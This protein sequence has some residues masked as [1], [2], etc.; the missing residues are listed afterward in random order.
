MAKNMEV[1]SN[2]IN[3]IGSG[4]TIEG[5]IT[6]TGDIRVDGILK[7]NLNTKGKV[8]IGES[9]KV[10]GEIYCKILEVEG[11]IE[12]KVFTS[13]LLSFRASSR[14]VGDITT[15][16]LAIEPGAVFS[17]KCDMTGTNNFNAAKPAEQKETPKE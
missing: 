12:G 5:N 4:T 10:I 16:K 11:N 7:G 15:N 3:L 2:T 13:E 1:D 14:L 9:G 17:G 8:I 6:S